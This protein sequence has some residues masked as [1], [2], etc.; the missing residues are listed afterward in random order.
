MEKFDRV[1]IFGVGL[2]GGSIALALKERGLCGEV[3]AYD[4]DPATLET[5][6]TLG[7]ADRV[8]ETLGAWVNTVDVGILAVP[9]RALP[10]LAESIAPFAADRTCWLDVGSV[11]HS[12]VSEVSQHL[13]RFVGTHPMAGLEHA[14]VAHA[15][16]GL[17]HNAIWAICPD[18]RTD[19][20][21]LGTVTALVRAL[22]AYPLE[23]DPA[24]HDRLVAR[25]SHV[26][27]VLAVALNLMIARDDA[28]RDPL[29]ALAAG[30]FRDLTRV[31]SGAVEMSRDMVTANTP[32]VR[33]ALDDLMDVVRSLAETLDEP[34]LFATEAAEA[35]LHRDA[36]PI[37]ART[38]LPS[39]HDVYVSLPDR[40][41]E[42]A[43]LTTTLGEAGVNIRDIEVLK[44]R[45]GRGEAIRVG[46][47]SDAFREA[48]LAA[49]MAAG[50]HVR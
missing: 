18:T 42:L 43:R 29:L 20:R 9:V 16:A 24:R 41:M 46:V 37:V 2:I 6:L 34:S 15:H 33:R 39:L 3:V 17:I 49:L 26:P 19:G 45:G 22:G 4:R 30:G 47:S 10:G 35:K 8:E 36:L 11:K 21:D 5:A 40:P 38:I 13:P 14:G 7:V 27:Y 23:L 25:V 50:Y 44:I 32:E 1:G 31:A 28:D 48:A 12:V